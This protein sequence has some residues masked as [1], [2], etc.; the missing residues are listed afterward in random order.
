MHPRN[1]SNAATSK[2]GKPSSNASTLRPPLSL[3]PQPQSKLSLRIARLQAKQHH[4]VTSNDLAQARLAASLTEVLEVFG[5]KLQDEAPH[6]IDM[7]H[8]ILGRLEKF[9]FPELTV[10]NIDKEE[11][12]FVAAE[13]A[14][15]EERQMVYRM[16]KGL[17]E[18]IRRR[19]EK[20]KKASCK[21]CN[22]R[23]ARARAGL[24]EALACVAREEADLADEDQVGRPGISG[25]SE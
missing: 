13:K 16:E 21:S 4:F 1:P 11:A 8:N 15:K 7:A 14:Q 3:D 12:F 2:T 10:D 18:V 24:N 25:E 9:R 23:R 5:K 22:A 17:D 20:D 6:I 19:Q